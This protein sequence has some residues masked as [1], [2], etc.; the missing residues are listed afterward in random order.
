LLKKLDEIL[1]NNPRLKNIYENILNQIPENLK[2]SFKLKIYY[3]YLIDLVLESIFFDKNHMKT[4]EVS[5]DNFYIPI[6]KLIILE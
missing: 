3:D 1:L 2:E 6:L 4:Q 5:P